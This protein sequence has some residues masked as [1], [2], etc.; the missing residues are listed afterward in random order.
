MEQVAR[1]GHRPARF[2][3]QVRP[4]DQPPDR[5]F[6]LVLANRDNVINVV[7]DVRES[8]VAQV[9]RPQT[10]GDSLPDL[11]RRAGYAVELVSPD[12]LEYRN[13]VLRKGNFAGLANALLRRWLRERDARLRALDADAVTRTAHPAW[14]LDA[15]RA[16]HPDRANDIAVAN[17][18]QAPLWLRA[19]ARRSPPPGASRK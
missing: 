13:G 10:V 14:L 15:F 7:L 18:A 9:L 5:L 19:N 1:E 11:F 2:G 16:D 8:D 17:N 3:H 6:N 12:Q 4:E